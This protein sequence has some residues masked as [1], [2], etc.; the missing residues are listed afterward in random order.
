MYGLHQAEIDA[1]IDPEVGALAFFG[2]AGLE[3]VPT[4]FEDD[5]LVGITIK[6]LDD[7][8]NEVSYTE[9]SDE[10]MEAARAEA[11]KAFQNL[12]I[13]KEPKCLLALSVR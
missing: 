7:D 11:A 1:D 4:N 3:V 13:A 6:S 8:G 12:G 2:D 5:D 10:D 9:L